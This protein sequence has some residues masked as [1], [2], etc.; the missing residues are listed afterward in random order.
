MAT[1]NWSALSDGQVIN[2]NPA[3]DKIHIDIPG[4]QA[5]QLQDW[6]WYLKNGTPTFLIRAADKSVEFSG[7]TIENFTASTLSFASGARFLAGDQLAGTTG[8]ANANTIVGSSAGD[9]LFG[10]DGND[11]LRGGIGDDILNGGAGD[12]A[13]DGG[14]G[15]DWASYSRD[16]FAPLLANLMTGK[17]YQSGNVDTVINIEG[18]RGGM[19]DDAFIGNAADNLFRGVGGLDYFNGHDG[20]DIV[21]YREGTGTQGAN[22]DL[23]TN[24]ATN[25]G[26][27]NADFLFNIEGILGTTFADTFKGDAF[28]NLLY[29]DAGNDTLTGNNGNDTLNGGAGIDR[30][31]GGAGNDTYHVDASTDVVSETSATG[32]IDTV[33]SSVTRTLGSYQEN[34]TL[35]G[36]VAINGTGNSS[37]NTLYGNDAANTLDGG[38]GKDILA[39][40]GGN[41]LLKGGLSA[42]QLAGGS[43]RDSFV[44]SRVQDSGTSSS[45]RDLIHDFVRGSDRIHLSAIDANTATTT[46]E[47]FTFIGSRAFNTNATAQLRYTYDAT[48][49]FGVLSGSTDADT[50]AEFSIQITG[51]P[52]L[53]ST[54]FVL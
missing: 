21:R 32:G 31:S 5:P 51:V 29:G 38:S 11:T 2:F 4:L 20:F 33:V 13:L 26:F 43:G 47:A 49:G 45:V 7:L 50:A 1:Y 42:D 40:G 28:D 48:K 16:S 52:S 6:N 8:D 3:V 39:G 41:D 14:A 19:G 34:L 10:L 22:V 24:S 15:M 46:N 37:A 36:N 30:M 17:I 23:S 25:D 9:L 18:V 44:F 54:D 12:D 35:V 53:G 27:G